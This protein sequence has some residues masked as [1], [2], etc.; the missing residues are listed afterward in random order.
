[1]IIYVDIDGTI[2]TKVKDG[3]YDK[4]TPLKD[5]IAIV[6]RL[7]DK[8]HVIIY[9]TARGTETGINW[10]GVTTRQLEE[11]GAKYHSVSFKKPTYDLFICDKAVNAASLKHLKE[12]GL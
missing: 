12:G 3:Q 8:G 2:C 7:Y 4:A 5:Q 10:T 9:W 6:N 11:W 1:M